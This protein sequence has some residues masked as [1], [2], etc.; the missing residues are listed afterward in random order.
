MQGADEVADPP[1][2][3]ALVVPPA[4]VQ[5]QHAAGVTDRERPDL[6]FHC[7][8]HHGFGGLVLGLADPPPVPGPG[9]PLASAVLPP[10]A[11][12]ALPGPGCPPG[13][14]DGAAF[15]VTEVLPALGADGAPGYQQLL[16]AWSGESVG[17][18]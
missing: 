7:P 5:V 1:V 17:G 8:G 13:G 10:A 14:G 12:P 15:A 16:P 2:A 11:G 9:R 6:A 3:G 4:G 18:G